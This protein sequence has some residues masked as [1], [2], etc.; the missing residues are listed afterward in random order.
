MLIF[1]E[2]FD[3]W[4]WK[5]NFWVYS[6]AIKIDWKMIDLKNE[7]KSR[8]PTGSRTFKDRDFFG[9]GIFFFFQILNPDTEFGSRKISFYRALLHTE[10]M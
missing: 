4:I 5:L 2:F 9:I 10:S 6:F 1:V 8:I 7:K 3:I